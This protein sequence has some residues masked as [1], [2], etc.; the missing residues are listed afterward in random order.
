MAEAPDVW[1]TRSEGSAAASAEWQNMP[2]LAPLPLKPLGLRLVLLTAWASTG[3][4]FAL[5][6][7]LIPIGLLLLPVAVAVLVALVTRQARNWP[8]VLGL[9]VGM[10]TLSGYIAYVNRNHRDCSGPDVV[11]LT[12]EEAAKLNFEGCTGTAPEP[13]LYLAVGL[14]VVAAVAYVVAVFVEVR[15]Q[16]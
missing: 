6:L 16:R 1:A 13:F 10:A 11:T 15:H 2:P 12:P 8:E 14:L 9:A 7:A 3:L 4:L 5:S